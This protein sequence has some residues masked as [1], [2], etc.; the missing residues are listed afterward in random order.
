MTL[1]DLIL[2]ARANLDDLISPYL[3]SDADLLSYINPSIETICQAAYLIYDDYS[4][5]TI[6]KIT[7]GI[8]YYA[9]DPRII[10]VR[11]ARLDSSRYPLAWRTRDWLENH[12]PTWAS[13]GAGHPQI[14]CENMRTGYIRLIPTP[15]AKLTSGE[16]SI[17]FANS[18]K[19]ITRGGGSFVSD[20]FIVGDKIT[21]DSANNPGPFYITTVSALA[22]TCSA[23]TFVNETATKTI[24]AYDTMRLMVYRLPLTPMS[25]SDLIASPE[26]EL[27]YHKYLKHGILARAYLKQ[28][29]EAYDIQKAEYHRQQFE[30]S[31]DGKIEGDVKKVFNL[32]QLAIQTAETVGVNKAFC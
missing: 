15:T 12:Y 5:F 4:D 3:W 7:P 25:L 11:E 9:K 1:A 32:T 8:P 22:I 23:A 20:G 14:G 17:T 10:R 24:S 21:T 19:T 30:G 27:K 18:G 13:A 16:L 29:N 2:E 31:D 26:F 6:I 28:D